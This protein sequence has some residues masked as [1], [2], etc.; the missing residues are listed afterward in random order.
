M[1]LSI[2]DAAG[3]LDVSEGDVYR[4]LDDGDFPARRFGE[5]IRFNRAE[6]LEWATLKKLPLSPAALRDLEG[7]ASL[8]RALEAGGIRRGLAGRDAGEALSAMI[9]ALPLPSEG[10]RNELSDMMLA[11]GDRA[12]SPVGGGIAFPHARQPA[13]LDLPGPAVALFFFWEPVE[14]G[15]PDGIPVGTFFFILSPTA[16]TH[17]RILSRLAAAL[18]D[19]GFKAAL[20]RRAESVEILRELERIERAA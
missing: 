14:L 12:W 15:A 5:E 4:W 8:V 20:A 2:R 7:G 3:L 11:R 19:P 16:R 13:V 6:L 18:R 17:L 9:R 10:D 1:Q